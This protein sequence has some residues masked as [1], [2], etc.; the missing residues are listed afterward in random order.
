M[1]VGYNTNGF[2]HHPLP[3]ALELLAEL[4]YQAVAITLDYHVLSP[5][6]PDVMQQAAQIRRLLEQR[7]LRSYVE[8][9]ARF[10][11]DPRRKHQPTLLSEPPAERERRI[12]F[13][14]RSLRIAAELGADGV[15]FWSGT[16]SPVA[17]AEGCPAR[18][19]L[20]D[21]FCAALQPILDLADRL[22]LPLALE[23]EPGMLIDT[24]ASALAIVRR[25][26][27]PRLGLTIDVGHVH[28]LAEGPIPGILTAAAP[29]LWNVHLEDMKVGRHDH[30]PFGEGD[31]DFPP[32]FQALAAIGYRG[33][34]YVELSR[35][36][37]DAIETARRSLAFLQGM[38]ATP[39]PRP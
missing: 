24:V 7:K 27:H 28:C 19:A 15:S 30:L 37:H 26:D 5:Y 14:C 32:I 18:I 4:G 39:T 11:L 36:S 23:P 6:A 2:A 12:D 1:F 22:A 38:F 16:P 31:I 20:E 21:R 25:L 3:V 10:L 17:A 9:G 29:W 13:L 33:G 34:V 8:T 35:H